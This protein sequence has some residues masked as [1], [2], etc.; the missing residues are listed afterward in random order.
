MN[1]G[2]RKAG[3]KNAAASP[4]GTRLRPTSISGTSVYNKTSEGAP[5]AN[6]RD[7]DGGSVTLRFA[8]ST[9]VD[10]ASTPVTQARQEIKSRSADGRQRPAYRLGEWVFIVSTS[11]DHPRRAKRGRGRDI[12]RA[13]RGTGVFGWKAGA[14][15]ISTVVAVSIQLLSVQMSAQRGP[16]PVL[17]Q[18]TWF[19]RSGTLMGKIGPIAD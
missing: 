17:S 3:G 7:G 18:L 1:T 12:M 6:T 11:Y 19:S 2:V 13:V 14:A 15:M 8:S 9:K 16:A 4:S 10:W 5:A